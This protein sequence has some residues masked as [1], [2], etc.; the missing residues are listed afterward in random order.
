M[1]VRGLLKIVAIALVA[2]VAFIIFSPKNSTGAADRQPP[3]APPSSVSVRSS[4]DFSSPLYTKG[5]ALVCP[6]QLAFD[7]REGHGLS[8]AI[9]AHLSPFDHEDKVEQLGCEEW[10]Q[11]LPVSLSPQGIRDAT[12]LDAKG[13]CGMV[14]FAAGYVFSCD[15]ANEP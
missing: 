14:E 8:E 10:K 6:V 9:Q 7:L 12:D 1:M 5:S 2:V 13:N 15:L 3:A 11:G 4:I